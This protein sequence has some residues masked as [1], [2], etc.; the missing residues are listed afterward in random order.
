MLEFTLFPF[1]SV[2]VVESQALTLYNKINYK[3]QSYPL[4]TFMGSST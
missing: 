4:P 2:S 3:N 1:Y